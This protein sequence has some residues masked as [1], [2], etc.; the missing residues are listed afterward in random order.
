MR[1]VHDMDVACSAESTAVARE[2]SDSPATDLACSD[3]H[4]AVIPLM[5]ADDM[6][7]VRAIAREYSCL[8]LAVALGAWLLGDQGASVWLPP[9]LRATLV[10]LLVVVVAAVQHRMSALAHEASHFVL[11]RKPLANELVSDL[12]LLFPLMAL[13]QRYRASHFGHHRFVNDPERD[14]DWMRLAAFEPMAFPIAKRRFWA[15]YVLRALWPPAILRYLLGRAKAANLAD[16]DSAS[17]PIKSVYRASVAKRMRGAFWLLVLT[18]VHATGGWTLFALFWIFPLVTFYPLFMLL[19][20]IAHH[21]NAP[22]DGLLTSSRLFEV[23]PVLGWAVFPYGQN[24]HLIH[25][26]FAS[27]PHHR[28]P[29]VHEIL[30]RCALFRES[31]TVCRG[32]FFR[33]RGSDGPSVLDLLSRRP[34]SRSAVGDPVPNGELSG[35]DGTDFKN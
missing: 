26:L 22:D 7:S 12:L 6:A 5:R 17:Q 10:A 11:F 23:H 20:E 14:P 25:H 33:R 31:V 30:Q 2:R 29:R 32:Y 24:F 15:R 27:I 4:R 9:A 8:V 18:L 19:R 28:L 3:V 16:S 35:I 13:T 1:N 34:R 21:A